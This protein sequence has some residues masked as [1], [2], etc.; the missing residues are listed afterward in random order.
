MTW[1][2]QIKNW[3]FDKKVVLALIV[4]GLAIYANAVPNKLFW[5]DYTNIV[6]NRYVRNFEI[7]KFFTENLGAGAGVYSRYYWRPLPL[8]V[9]SLE[10]QNWR[11]WAPNYHIVNIALH[12][13]N[14]ALLYF[15]LLRLIR[16]RWISVFVAL[17][18]LIHPAQTEA[19][20]F[21][22]GIA[23]PLAAF[24]LFLSIFFYLNQKKYG[25][26]LSLTSYGFALLS[27]E[28]TIV[29]PLLLFLTHFFFLNTNLSWREKIK[30]GANALWPYLALALFYIIIRFLIM[31]YE[32]TVFLYNVDIPLGLGLIERMV[33]FFRIL[34]LYLGLLFA[35]INLHIERGAEL[36]AAPTS[37]LLVTAGI[38]LFIGLFTIAV[39]SLKRQL[40]VSFGILWFFVTLVPMSGVI[41]ISNS[42]MREHWLYLPLIG[43]FISVGWIM[44]RIANKYHLRKA[45]AMTAGLFLVFLAAL[46]IQRNFDWRDEFTFFNKT[47]KYVP[48]SYLT[49][50]NLGNA[51]TKIK[52][53][54]T[55]EVMFQ[56]AIAVS[57]DRPTAYYNL[58][59]LYSL[60]GRREAAIEQITISIAKDKAFVF[61]YAGLAQLLTEMGRAQEAEKIWEQYFSYATEATRALKPRTN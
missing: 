54:E 39:R 32:R 44:T 18:F 57:P 51:Y 29:L 53:Y 58:G 56:K 24:F 10:W 23:D 55:A 1:W 25:Y 36:L 12:I 21:I 30:R 34:P 38:A 59:Q 40:V 31:Q 61:G 14:A 17:A 13:A 2:D 15:I 16:H 3:P 43:F 52:N 19:V 33:L 49:L 41:A 20:T 47:L 22:S 46:T 7:E 45:I 35:P 48:N 11:D 27:K 6:N 8:L 9:L 50:T 26:S 5:D 37:W 28:G 4:T 42:P 60:M